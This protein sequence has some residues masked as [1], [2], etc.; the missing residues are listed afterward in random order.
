MIHRLAWVAWVGGTLVV[1][2][3]TRN[4][5]YL[6]LALVCIAVV[7]RVLRAETWTGQAP[8]A[9]LRF[10]MVVIPLSAVFNALTVHVGRNELL[11]LPN[12]FPLLGGPITLEALMY[13]TLNGVVLTGIFAAFTVLNRALP[14]RSLVRLIP[15][16][17]HQVAV[18][19]SIALTYVPTTL[20]QF[21][22][23]R[24]AQAIRGHRTRGLRDWVPL[25]MPLLIGGLERA[26]QLAEAMTARGFASSGEKSHDALTRLVIAQGLF[27]LL[28]G[29]LLR[30]VWNQ[31]VLGLI[32]MIAGL[33]LV[34]AALWVVGH[35]V[36]HTDYRPELWAGRDWIVV[37][38]AALAAAPFLQPVPGLNRGTIFYYPYP[39]LT[40]PGFDPIIGA[41]LLGL[42]APVLVLWEKSA[43]ID[44]PRVEV[45]SGADVEG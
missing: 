24:E 8:G 37:L 34:L 28:I 29:W 12:W 2:S 7:A 6:A 42:L 10:G 36:P 23:I 30:L 26:L 15:R 35:R 9:P 3:V 14:V 41:A 33:A 21:Q 1:L 16:A 40:L 39:A 44:Q 19:I 5:F 4:P 22:Q 27:A 43:A 18:V 17:F 38:G 25:F 32:L 11:R 20:R 45:L 13:G 31:R